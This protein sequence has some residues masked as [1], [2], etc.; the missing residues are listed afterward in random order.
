MNEKKVIDKFTTTN[1]VISEN[2]FSKKLLFIINPNSGKGNSEQIFFTQIKP[3]F[4]KHTQYKLDYCISRYSNHI[5]SYIQTNKDTLNEYDSLII[6]GGDG[7][8]HLTLNS[9]L[10][11]KLDIPLGIIPTGSGNGLV[12]SM[13]YERCREEYTR[14][15]CYELIKEYSIKK[16]DTIYVSSTSGYL[17]SFLA[18]SWGIVS[19]LDINTEFIIK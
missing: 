9:L 11:N 16:I 6:L 17:T 12:K 10:K 18:I 15:D 19:D 8:M 2:K 5:N 14:L 13:F 4:E 3:Y 7:M 1:D